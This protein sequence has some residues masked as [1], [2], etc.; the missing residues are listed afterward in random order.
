MNVSMYTFI[1]VCAYAQLWTKKE[2]SNAIIPYSIYS[3]PDFALSKWGGFA[4]GCQK[5]QNHQKFGTF[6]C[7]NYLKN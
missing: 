6:L 7:T 5:N 1:V 2:I 3:Q 4:K